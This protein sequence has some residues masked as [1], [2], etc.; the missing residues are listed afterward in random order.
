LKLV[1]RP[2]IDCEKWDNL[3]KSNSTN[4]VFSLSCYLDAVA[5]HWCVLVNDTY[6]AGIALPYTIRLGIKCC[7]TPIFVRY[8]TF[9][10]LEESTRTTIL[11]CIQEHFPVGQ[12][13]VSHSAIF[14]ASAASDFVY[15]VITPSSPISLNTQAKRMLS[16]YSKADFTRIETADENPLFDIISRELPQK[17]ASINTTSLRLLKQLITALKQHNLLHVMMVE[18]GNNIPEGGVFLVRFNTSLLYLKGAF[19]AEAKKKGTM[20]ALMHQSIQSAQA[21]GLHFDFG[22]S[23]V[24]G[25]RR[26]NTNLGGEDC[27]Y[28]MVEWNNAP[29]WFNQLKKL[30][31][32]IKTLTILR[33]KAPTKE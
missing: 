23:R 24:E 13:C 10:G 11:E 5:E 27:A 19:S 2:H 9:F 17:I 14:P 3:V 21:D 33:R 30:K 25:V 20:Y 31:I 28:T 8:V 4:A 1:E 26:F 32:K 15:Q 12:L 29:W 22:G 6:T 16:T 18:N 7:Y